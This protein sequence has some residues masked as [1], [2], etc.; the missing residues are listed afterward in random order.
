MNYRYYFLAILLAVFTGF[1]SHAQTTKKTYLVTSGE[2]IFSQSNASFTDD[3]LKLYPGAEMHE[4]R[5]RF[6]V[7]FHIGQ[8]VHHDFNNSLGFFTGLGIRNVGMITDETLPQTVNL[9]TTSVAYSNY[10]IVKRQY[11]LG[12]PLALKIGSFKN[13]M[14]LFAGG[15]Y[16]LAFVF[17][18]K[19]WS[20]TWDRSGEK[21]KHNDWF[22]DQTPLFMP[23][24]FGGIQF[25]GGVNIRFK[26]Y[27]TDFLNHE[28]TVDKNKQAGSTYSLSDLSRYKQSEVFYI[29]VCWQFNSSKISDATKGNEKFSMR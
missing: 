2:L 23:S 14:Y 15:E 17:K 27:L 4:S 5:T 28:F 29:S 25:P 20:D 10:K 16:E 12:L 1:L 7:F 8:Y 3:F 24:V 26:Y 6:T 9:D 11:T 13:H 22:G 19:Y 21:T 18:E